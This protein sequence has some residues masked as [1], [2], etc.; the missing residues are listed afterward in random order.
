MDIFRITQSIEV[1]EED[2]ETGKRE[3]YFSRI[4]DMSEESL[5]ITPPF[6][7]GFYLPPRQGRK[8]VARLPADTCSY[9]FE[10]VLLAYHSSSLP[11]WE[12]SL[13][14][15][16]KRVQMREFVRLDIALEI[17]IEFTDASGS[18]QSRVSMSKNISAGG[19]QVV[20]LGPLPEKTKLNMTFSLSPQDQLQVEGELVR[21][22]PPDQV[23]DK[24]C[25]AIKFGK[26]EEK[27]RQQIIKFIFQEQ[28]ERRKKEREL[29]E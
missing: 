3:L 22:I 29:F 18:E 12:I 8:I 26:I 1:L 14:S 5:F 2:Q 27:A 15:T 4:E 17:K 13:P 10:A 20:L 21:I 24:T 16:I 7:R 25:V 11:L 28:L 23:G 6:R 9:L 19:V